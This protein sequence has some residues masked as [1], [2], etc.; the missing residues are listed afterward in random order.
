MK[1]RIWLKANAALMLR[2]AV[3]AGGSVASLV[4]VLLWFLPQQSKIPLWAKALLVLSALLFIG[5][6]WLELRANRGRRLFA[7]SD[8]DGIKKYMHQWIEHGGRVAIW[9]RDMSW[10]DNDDTRNL[11]KRK[12]E[13][14]ELILCL[15]TQNGFTREL[16]EAGAQICAYGSDRLESPASRF[17]ISFFGRHGARVAVGHAEGDTHVIDEF[18]AG[19]HPAFYLAQDLVDVIRREPVNRR[20][21]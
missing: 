5:L 12:A 9:T 8:K 1:L 18:S 21:D 4:G 13:R 3:F 10:V 6:V 17:T 19:S 7:T 2:L 15:P 14:G 16:Q 11:L 20:F